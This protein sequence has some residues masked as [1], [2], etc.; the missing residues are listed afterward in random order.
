[1]QHV[2]ATCNTVVMTMSRDKLKENVARI[3]GFWRQFV[4]S[5]RPPH[6][7]ATVFGAKTAE[8]DFRVLNDF[9]NG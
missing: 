1:M 4:G 7:A 6:A 9:H 8:D 3:L 5:P 2:A